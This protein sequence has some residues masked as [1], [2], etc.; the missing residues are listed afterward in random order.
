MGAAS[1][2]PPV[3]ERRSA[4]R[5][6]AGPKPVTDV[7]ELERQRMLA[8][9]LNAQGRTAIT[10]AADDYFALG[11]TLP[12]SA[13]A[14]T[15]LLEHRDEARVAEA[16]AWLGELLGSAPPPRRA[17]LEARLR[18]IEEL[19]EES[20]TQEA[21]AELRRRISARGAEPTSDAF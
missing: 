6:V 11:H 7:K 18:S 13:E 12:A 4:A 10:R 21:A 17:V 3:P 9:L 16:I 5:I 15:Q 2:A 8:R 20:S 14:W 1:A 19:A